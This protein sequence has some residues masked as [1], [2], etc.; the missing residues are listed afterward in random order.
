ME[1]KSSF[2]SKKLKSRHKGLNMCDLYS[3]LSNYP[4]ILRT[5]CYPHVKSQYI[6]GFSS[7]LYS[8][9]SYYPPV[10]RTICYP[11]VKSQYILGFSLDLYSKLSYY[12]PVLRTICYQRERGQWTFITLVPKVL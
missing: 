11:H 8:K 5:I 12:P 9:L 6:L 7:D 1:L 10:L 4:P 3:K 2:T